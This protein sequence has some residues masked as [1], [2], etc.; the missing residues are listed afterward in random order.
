MQL[1]FRAYGQ[2][3]PLVILHGLFGA[4]DNWH[5]LA[6]RLGERF[7]VIVPDLRNHGQ[8]PHGDEMTYPLMAGDVAEL[9]AGQGLAGADVLGHSMGGK[10]AMQLALTQPALVRKLIVADM[11]PR[12]YTPLHNEIIAAL[13][14]LDV[15]SYSSRTEI[16]EVL[17]GPIPSLNLRRFLLKNLG[18]TAEGKFCW[19][20]NVAGI[21]AG[22]ANLRAP[23]AGGPFA[24]PAL[25]I[26]GAKSEYIRAAGEPSIREFFP[27][28]ELKTIEN[29]GHW[30]HADAPEEFL[31]LVR[32]FLG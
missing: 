25:F 13:A 12:G 5:S 19:K 10:V 20:I 15:A 6:T 28:A 9:L 7:H 22:Y 18:R 8:S 30:L 1:Y 2:G 21:A 27:G 3:E 29:A 31:G 24:G 32:E 23:V 16:E 11:A 26:R 17:A 14:A 4:S